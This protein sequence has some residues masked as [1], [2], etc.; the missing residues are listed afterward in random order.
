[1]G[2]SVTMPAKPDAAPAAL[3]AR[4]VK[5]PQTASAPPFFAS[6][7]V[8]D[9]PVPQIGPD[10]ADEGIERLGRQVDAVD[11]RRNQRRVHSSAARIAGEG[12]DA[13]DVPPRRPVAHRADQHAAGLRPAAARA[14][15][16]DRPVERHT[17]H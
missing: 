9:V 2:K 1:M 7:A 3:S 16:I 4:S 13:G 11:R 15:R 5:E 6:V 10:D 8:D 12:M 14:E 17:G